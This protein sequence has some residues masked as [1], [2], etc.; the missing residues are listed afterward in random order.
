[1]ARGQPFLGTSDLRS[2]SEP[3]PP[4]I[5]PQTIREKIILIKKFF[6]D[7]INILLHISTYLCIVKLCLHVQRFHYLKFEEFSEV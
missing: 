2:H 1:M 4:E 6:K 3:G 5:R 7:E